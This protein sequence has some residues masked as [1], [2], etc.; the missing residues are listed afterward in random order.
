LKSSDANVKKEHDAIPSSSSALGRRDLMKIGAGVVMTTLAGAGAAAQEKEGEAAKPRS[1][2]PQADG[3]T[4]LTGAGSYKND[5]NRIAGN[6]PM[7]ETSRQ[8]VSYVN[9]FPESNL[10]EPVLAGLSKTMMDSIAA[11]IA[12]FDS[13]PGRI[14]ARL[15]RSNQS[16]LKSTVAGYG[17]TTNPESAAFANS[18]MMRHT[19]YNDGDPDNGGHSSVI[20]SG[21]L[22]IGEAVHSTGSQVLSAVAVGY[23]V[24]N[25]LGHAGR[26]GGWDAPYEG[27]ATALACGK[28]LGLNDDKLANALSIALVP[29]MPLG[30][31]HVG[32][33]SM[34]K[35][36]HSAMGVRN[37]VYAALLAHEG[38]TAPA[39]PF[40]GRAG[41]W[42]KVTG[43]YRELRLP[44]NP[45][46]LAVENFRLKRYPAEGNAQAILQ[47][48]IPPMREFAKVDDIE[49]IR[50]EVSFGTWQEI[51]DPPKWD[52]R[53]RETAD[54]SLAYM[55]AVALTDGEV[56]LSSFT[57]KRYLEDASIKQLMQKITC[58][59]NP[60]YDRQKQGRVR[61]TMRTKSGA[62]FVKDVMEEN[63]VSH[64]EVVA[65][66]NRVCGYMSVPEDRR[67]RAR[68]MWAGLQKV[69]DI[70]E[71]MRDL[72]HFGRTLSI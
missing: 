31:T 64:E 27:P 46:R 13:E 11:L 47:Q 40:E 69:H 39:Q 44:Y 35:G 52:P 42:D 5:A 10:T 68:T 54:H 15:G 41:L 4:V 7:D 24:L 9:S 3:V 1:S 63:P 60:D 32:A 23:E 6:G 53:N 43:P 72:G 8:I 66:F 18:S 59:A 57:P 28:L 58:V 51:A 17:V 70:A 55:V 56:Y 21:I 26:A 34:W 33:L 71:P 12:G 22:A 67:D 65:K 29:H 2:A 20:I 38:I 62:N 49:S 36:C 19:D 50:L 30:V 48:G 25:G 14:G 61:I 37:G 16:N 45:G